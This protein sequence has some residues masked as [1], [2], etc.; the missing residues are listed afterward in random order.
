MGTF[1]S[2]LRQYKHRLLG[3]IGRDTHP[4]HTHLGNNHSHHLAGDYNRGLSATGLG[5]LSSLSLGVVAHQ[6][7]AQQFAPHLE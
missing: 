1:R 4:P 7:V 5:G 6:W 2:H 3:K